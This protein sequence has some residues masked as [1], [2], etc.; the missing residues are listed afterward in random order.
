VSTSPQLAPTIFRPAGAAL[1]DADAL[2]Q[3]MPLAD[4]PPTGAA[5]GDDDLITGISLT[6]HCLP[7]G[8]A[9][10]ARGFEPFALP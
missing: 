2:P 7:L 3:P 4:A 8:G 10:A 6:V 9:T 5:F 1:P